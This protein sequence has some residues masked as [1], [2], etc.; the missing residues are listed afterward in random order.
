MS[1]IVVEKRRDYA[2]EQQKLL[3]ENSPDIVREYN[4]LRRLAFPELRK[5]EKRRS[6]IRNRDKNIRYSRDYVAVNRSAVYARNRRWRKANP[7]A[8]RLNRRVYMRRRCQTD[9]LFRAIVA[10]RSRLYHAIRR[11]RAKKATNTFDLTG[12]NAQELLSH[13]ASQ[14]HDGMSWSNYG[15]WEIDHIKPCKD[16]N[17]LDPNEQKACFHYSN[18]RPLW[19]RDNRARANLPRAK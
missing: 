6:Y 2:R 5:A 19:R 7:A 16:F 4:R 8:I 1:P 15:A 12:C 18:L 9:P 14:F 3:R 17:L 11:A 13:I 10:V